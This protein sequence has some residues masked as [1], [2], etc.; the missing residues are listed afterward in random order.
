MQLRQRLVGK[1][2]P[3]LTAVLAG[4]TI[5]SINLPAQATVYDLEWSQSGLSSTPVG[6]VTVTAGT[7]AHVGQTEIDVV[8]SANYT[9]HQS[10]A[11]QGHHA[12]EFNTSPVTTVAGTLP[13]G[14]TVA[15]GGPFSAPPF[16]PSGPNKD[17]W[18][19]ALD[20]A[21]STPT[22]LDFYITGAPSLLTSPCGNFGGSS[23]PNCSGGSAQIFFVA[24]LV[25][26]SGATGNWGAAPGNVAAPGPV[27]G[28]GLAGLAALALAGLY[29]RS[30]RA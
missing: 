14:F 20:V 6:T 10:N 26:P 1:T 15:S 11:S 24:D 19:N 28:A 27:P 23:S 8:L 17:I 21:S 7:G 13:S 2:H 12:F 3:A 18:S 30:R 29:A 22:S 16:Q 5:L 9:F 4:L 25:D